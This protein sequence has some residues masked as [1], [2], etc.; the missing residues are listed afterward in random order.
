M[1]QLLIKKKSSIHTSFHDEQFQ[2]KNW[3]AIIKNNKIRKTNV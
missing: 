3:D 1:F 2:N